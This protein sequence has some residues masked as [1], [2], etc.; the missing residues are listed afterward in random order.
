M[1]IRDSYSGYGVRRDSHFVCALIR[2][3][4]S[5]SFG[6]PL[7]TYFGVVKMKKAVFS[8]LIMASLLSGCATLS[9]AG[10]TLCGVP[11]VSWV[12]DQVQ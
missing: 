5:V 4:G 6:Q 11:G 3:R 1:C 2:Y 10:A 12:C 8:V 9:D 7:N